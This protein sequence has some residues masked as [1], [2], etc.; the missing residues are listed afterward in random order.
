MK[1]PFKDAVCNSDC[2]AY[3][4]GKCAIIEALERIALFLESSLL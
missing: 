1:C 3:R 2:Q 4:D